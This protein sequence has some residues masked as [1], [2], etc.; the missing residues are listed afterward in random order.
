MQTLNTSTAHCMALKKVVVVV[1]AIYSQQVPKCPP[2]A[3][4]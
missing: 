3:M 1:G 4:T 2:Q